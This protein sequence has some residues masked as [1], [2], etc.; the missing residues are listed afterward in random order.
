[1]ATKTR[2]FSDKELAR[3]AAALVQ[4]QSGELD[5]SLAELQSEC[6]QDEFNQYRAAVANIMG[7]MFVEILEPIWEEFPEL[8][9]E[10]LRDQ[11]VK[12]SE[13]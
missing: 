10:D 13:E 12:E 7:A 4:R 6:T 2:L 1:M 5:A 9:P 8:A 11:Y 3:R